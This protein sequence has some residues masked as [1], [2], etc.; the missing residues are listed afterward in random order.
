MRKYFIL[1]MLLVLFGLS[2][3]V[4]DSL[5]AGKYL[6]FSVDI[7]YRILIKDEIIQPNRYRFIITDPKSCSLKIFP[8]NIKFKDSIFGSKIDQ[9]PIAEVQSLCIIENTLISKPSVKL[10]DGDGNLLIILFKTPD[11]K[12][13]KT[14]NIITVIQ[15]E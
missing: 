11:Y 12:L 6:E 9:K 15:K 3:S 1:I 13:K 10:L 8:I 7:P 5:G 2:L 4:K 14:L